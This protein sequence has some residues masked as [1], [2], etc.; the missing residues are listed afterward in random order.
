MRLYTG[1]FRSGNYAPKSNM[2]HLQELL[3][4]RNIEDDSEIAKALPATNPTQDN[5]ISQIIRRAH[6][7]AKRFTKKTNAILKANDT[8]SAFIELHL[9]ADDEKSK[10]LSSLIFGIDLEFDSDEALNAQN[11]SIL[12]TSSYWQEGTMDQTILSELQTALVDA[13]YEYN[14]EAWQHAYKALML[15]HRCFH[16]GG[17]AY[18]AFKSDSVAIIDTWVNIARECDQKDVNMQAMRLDANGTLGSSIAE[19]LMDEFKA[20]AEKFD[21]PDKTPRNTTLL[22]KLDEIDSYW[23]FIDQNLGYMERMKAQLEAEKNKVR[24]IVQN[25]VS[26]NETES[27]SVATPEKPKRRYTKRK[28]AEGDDKGAA[29]GAAEGADKGAAVTLRLTENGFATLA[30][31]REMLSESPEIAEDPA[32]M[33]LDLCENGLEIQEALIDETTQQL[34]N[35]GLISR[36]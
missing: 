21:C 9:S 20:M 13:Q 28:G 16:V 12:K 10:N 23:D 33:I 2:R 36:S 17:G 14:S 31:F 22:A 35:E 8:G 26:Q 4:S 25:L 15:R 1:S 34:I 30:A 29:E 24:G 6:A 3:K 11:L 27:A 5:T 18:F 19:I 7:L 32:Y